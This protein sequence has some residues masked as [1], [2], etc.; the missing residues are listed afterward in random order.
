MGALGLLSFF[1]SM[2]W[3][4][5]PWTY[6]PLQLLVSF[7]FAYAI[8]KH[9]LIP[10]RVALRRAC[11]IVKIYVTLGFLLIPLG[12]FVH[13][14]YFTTQPLIPLFFLILFSGAL[15]SLGPIVYARMIRRSA[16]F[17]DEMTSHITHEFKTPLNA[18]QS[19]QEILDEELRRP[20]P[21]SAKVHDYMNMIQRNSERL[22]AFVLEILN[23]SKAGANETI[24]EKNRVDMQRLCAE[25]IARLP[26][27][28]G[29]VEVTATGPMDALASA[30]GIAQ[31]FSNLLSNAAKFS[32]E[33]KIRVN[34]T[35][36]DA[37]VEVTIEDRG[38][39]IAE[40][41]LEKIF[42]PFVTSKPGNPKGSG[43]GLAI[44]KRWVE[45]HNGRVWAE[46]PGENRGAKFTFVIP[47]K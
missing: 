4:D 45:F 5:L 38:C 44:V 20:T 27:I 17:Q 6:Y 46:S 2:I 21:D 10:I 31:I 35:G 18:I 28:H 9:D 12:L 1:A 26:M 23:F 14:L 19:A 34:I 8:F 24:T 40:K 39:G 32:P 42:E 41:D 13:R 36:N 47:R 37:E 25:T 22:E 43:L 30:E 16:L 11:L 7:T 33:G 3:V 29:R 15:F